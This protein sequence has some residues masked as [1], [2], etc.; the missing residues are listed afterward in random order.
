MNMHTSRFL[1]SYLLIVT[2]P[3]TFF[4]SGL[5]ADGER[6]LN[7]LIKLARGDVAFDR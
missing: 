6:V 1:K 4:Y 2:N 7:Y 5:R 3:S